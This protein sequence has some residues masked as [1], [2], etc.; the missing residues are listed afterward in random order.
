MIWSSASQ[1]YWCSP[2]WINQSIN[3][4]ISY[5]PHLIFCR[6]RGPFS[7]ATVLSGQ[8]G[9]RE[10]LWIWP[11]SSSLENAG[12]IL[13][14]RAFQSCMCCWLCCPHPPTH[15]PVALDRGEELAG[16]PGYSQEWCFSFCAAHKYSLTLLWSLGP[17]T[18]ILH[19]LDDTLD[20]TL[21]WRRFL[22]RNF[23]TLR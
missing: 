23:G 4:S 15:S 22:A 5:T 13:A 9:F 11:D 10:K 3:Q 12:W 8:F 17:V 6:G 20:C 18:L 2:Q 1:P 16:N 21:T 14:V 7:L 19:H